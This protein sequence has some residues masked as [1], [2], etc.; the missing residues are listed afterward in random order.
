MRLF[1][2]VNFSEDMLSRLWQL[3][4]ELAGACLSGRPTWRENFHLTLAFLGEQ[5]SSGP[6]A[7]AMEAVDGEA[8]TLRT[9]EL[10]SFSR[11]DG[12]LWWLS[13]EPCP[14]LLDI[15]RRLIGELLRRGFHPDAKPFR[16]HLTLV[17]EAVAADGQGLPKLQ[18]PH[19]E[20][21]VDC[22]SLMLSQRIDGR[23]NYRK[24]YT[25]KLTL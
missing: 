8:F 21:T 16:P 22:Y 1:I 19:W 23:L 18:P 6:V 10:G 11:R 3:S 12:D 14:A 13:L 4:K 15:Q 25:R 5:S 24:L 7:E 17:R 20:E 2:A 9:A